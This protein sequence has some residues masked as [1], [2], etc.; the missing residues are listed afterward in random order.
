MRE[1][2]L[3]DGTEPEE[4]VLSCFEKMAGQ[5]GGCLVLVIGQEA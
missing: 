3:G 1:G 5:Q 4:I 2:K